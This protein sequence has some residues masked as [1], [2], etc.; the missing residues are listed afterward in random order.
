MANNL[1]ANLRGNA[2]LKPANPS[3]PN[4]ANRVAEQQQSWQPV[5]KELNYRYT[6]SFSGKRYHEKMVQLLTRN[7]PSRLTG[8]A[9]SLMRN[10]LIM[11]MEKLVNEN[12][13]FFSPEDR[14]EFETLLAYARQ[15][16]E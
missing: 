4:D 12:P 16:D 14:Q 2:S 15:N 1:A 5:P 6:M 8:N 9:S 10:G 7:L 3:A 13:E 11:Y